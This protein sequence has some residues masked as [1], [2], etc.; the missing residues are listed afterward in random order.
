MRKSIL[1]AFDGRGLPQ[2]FGTKEMR[3]FQR[4]DFSVDAG[5][6]IKAHDRTALMRLVR[7]APDPLSPRI[8]FLKVGKDLVQ[9]CAEQRSEQTADKR[10][11]KLDELHLTPLELI[12]RIAAVVPPLRTHR[13]AYAANSM[14]TF[15]PAVLP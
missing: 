14:S 11:A 9:P 8:A 3:G 7:V 6:C 5:V 1:R 15:R 10:G 13:L 12:D 4:S 2:S